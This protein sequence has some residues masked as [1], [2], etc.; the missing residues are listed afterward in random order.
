LPASPLVSDVEVGASSVCALHGGDA[1][2]WGTNRSGQLGAGLVVG[3]DASSTVVSTATAV[4]RTPVAS[5]ALPAG[6]T[7]TDISPGGRM[8]GASTWCAVANV[9]GG[10]RRPYCWGRG[11]HGQ[12][13]TALLTDSNTA[14]AIPAPPS[15]GLPQ[16]SSIASVAG[17]ERTMFLVPT[18]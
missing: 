10:P 2:C 16:G 8:D 18:S 5:S 11:L 14:R 12:L 3:T 1:F 9:P 13:G 15:G 6:A 4:V 7:V 17:G